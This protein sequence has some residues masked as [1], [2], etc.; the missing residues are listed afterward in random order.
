[1]KILLLGLAVVFLL[2]ACGKERQPL[3]VVVDIDSTITDN[4]FNRP[5]RLK[6]AL[7][8]AVGALNRLD[9]QG[10]A[11]IYLTKRMVERRTITALWLEMRRFPS[12]AELILRADSAERGSDFKLRELDSL[13]KRYDIVCAMGDQDDRKVYASAGLFA[14][15]H[16]AWRDED[17][18]A[19]EK[20]V[21]EI[22]RSRRGTKEP[23][24]E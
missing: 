14:I 17:W 18:L 22:I 6:A 4:R 10:V 21:D 23:E 2:A 24:K 20:V 15:I 11:V 12:G 1:M 7:G 3:A 5:L 9:A 8:S 13:K 19:A 16:T